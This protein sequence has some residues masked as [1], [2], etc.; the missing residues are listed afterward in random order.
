MMRAGLPEPL[1]TMNAQALSLVAEG[2]AEW[3]SE[4][5]TAVLG[6]PP[7]S[8]EQFATDY[9]SAFSLPTAAVRT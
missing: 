6:R 5:V 7:R 1:A 4:D 9:A 3:L 2:D 8:F